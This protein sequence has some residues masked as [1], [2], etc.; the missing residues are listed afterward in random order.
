MSFGKGCGIRKIFTENHS[1]KW[2]S[3]TLQKYVITEWGFFEFLVYQQ[4]GVTISLSK[5][6]GYYWTLPKTKSV[7]KTN[8]K[9]MTSREKAYLALR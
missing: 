4:Y 6:E 3:Y 8:V 9:Y 7:F 1:N 2:I 5:G